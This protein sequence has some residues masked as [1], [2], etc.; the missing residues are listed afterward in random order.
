MKILCII[1]ARSGSKGIPDKNIRKINGIP[2]L[3]YSINQALSSNYANNMKIVVS[4]DSEEYRKIALSYGAEV[5]FLRP[6]EISGD[7]STDYECFI[8][9]LDYLSENHKYTPDLV[10]HLRPTQPMRTVKLIDDCINT[11]LEIMD[12]YDSL[13]TIIP[14]KKSPYKM[15]KSHSGKEIVPL[16]ETNGLHN[17]GR[18]VLPKTFLHNGYVDIIKPAQILKRNTDISGKIYG[19]IMEQQNDLDIDDYDDLNRFKTIM[20]CK[21]E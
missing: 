5:P 16:I 8:H 10:I 3:A 1:P 21:T 19:Y 15:Y 20:D 11:F 17:K 9:C 12:D 13:R 14:C 6:K 2:L 18:Q 7:F 4:T